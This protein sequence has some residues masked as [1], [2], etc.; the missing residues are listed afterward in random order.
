MRRQDA[1][2]RCTC[3]AGG[4]RGGGGEDV[5]APGHRCHAPRPGV[6]RAYLA[7]RIREEEVRG[8]LA[9]GV[10]LKRVVEVLEPDCRRPRCVAGGR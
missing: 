6:P 2:G 1:V 7:A 10:G 3:T 5:G 4:G 8:V 9:G